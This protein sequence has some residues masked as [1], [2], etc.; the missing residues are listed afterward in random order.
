MTV[1]VPLLRQGIWPTVTTVGSEEPPKLPPTGGS[2][3]FMR[4]L[5]GAT[6]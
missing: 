1:F 2:S 5:Q 3:K 4:N 6:H